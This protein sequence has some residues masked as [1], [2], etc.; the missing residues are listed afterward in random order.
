MPMRYLR[1]ENIMTVKIGNYV[2]Y[3]AFFIL[4]FGL[5]IG[6]LLFLFLRNVLK[7]KKQENKINKNFEITKWQKK[8]L[9][10]FMYDYIENN[11]ISDLYKDIV[12]KFDDYIVNSKY[13]NLEELLEIDEHL[14]SYS[15]LILFEIAQEAFLNEEYDTSV[16]ILNAI[17]FI[18]GGMDDPDYYV[19]EYP[20]IGDS[21]NEMR[22]H[23]DMSDEEARTLYLYA[24]AVDDLFS[25]VDEDLEKI[26]ETSNVLPFCKDITKKDIE[27]AYG[28]LCSVI[29]ILEINDN[30]REIVAKSMFNSISTLLGNILDA[31]SENYVQYIDEYRR[32]SIRALASDID[33]QLYS[34]VVASIDD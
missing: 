2:F 7:E 28:D 1:K 22:N 14:V 6:F 26:P 4:I 13:W 10:K 15:S 8:H 33:K 31:D 21:V 27:D 11:N 32:Y 34:D 23:K 24:S 19:G 5:F 18:N 25:F 3:P 20:W 16:L 17:D 29:D 12:D 9:T 30:T